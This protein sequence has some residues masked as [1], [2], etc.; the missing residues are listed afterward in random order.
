MN[1]STNKQWI[2]VGAIGTDDETQMFKLRFS[3]RAEAS[4]FCA[5]WEGLPEA[6]M[7]VEDELSRSH[8]AYRD[9]RMY[10]VY[11]GWWGS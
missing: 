11:K 1:I 6:C 7:Q 5:E 10:Q 2:A 9:N 4:A 8:V 3:S